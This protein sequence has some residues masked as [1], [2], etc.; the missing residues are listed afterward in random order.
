MKY[1]FQ[2]FSFFLS[3]PNFCPHTPRA[4]SRDPLRMAPGSTAVKGMRGCL[5][6]VGCP[7]PPSH[8]ASFLGP[9][10]PSPQAKHFRRSLFG[11]S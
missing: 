2:L 9:I 4:L 8:L 7:H 1:I 3:P 10:L 11:W 6:L 5:P